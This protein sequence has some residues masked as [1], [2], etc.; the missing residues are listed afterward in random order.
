MWRAVIKKRQKGAERRLFF[1]LR[2]DALSVT[3]T[4]AAIGTQAQDSTTHETLLIRPR[5]R[6][7]VGG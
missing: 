4:G 3:L 6:C 2:G 1:A 7:G 5:L